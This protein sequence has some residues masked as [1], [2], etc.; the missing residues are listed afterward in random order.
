[1]LFLYLFLFY[2]L[3]LLWLLSL[4]LQI[5][6]GWLFAKVSFW[7][8]TIV[9]FTFTTYLFLLAQRFLKKLFYGDVGWFASWFFSLIGLFYF[10]TYYSLFLCGACEGNPFFNPLILF[11]F[12]PQVLWCIK[13]I[14]FVGGLSC[15]VLSILFFLL[16]SKR[17]C[18]VYLGGS[19]IC[20][21]PLLIG[22]I[23]YQP[24]KIDTG[25]ICFIRPWWHTSKDPMYAGY[26][27][28][29][30]VT[31]CIHHNRDISTIILPESSFG[32]NIYH[33]SEFIPMLSDY[34]PEVKVMFGGQRLVEG[35]L[36]NCYLAVKKGQI[37]FSYDKQ[38][39]V[40][41]MERNSDFLTYIGYGELLCSTSDTFVPGSADQ[42]DTIVING[43]LYQL[44]VCSELLHESKPI[45]G[46]PILF[47][48]NDTWFQFS[49]MRYW[50]ML[51]VR[52]IELRY[53][54]PVLFCTTSGLSNI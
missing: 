7:L 34:S 52:Y 15:I 6:K 39:L 53:D 14:G 43:M 22:F 24:H 2:T 3:Q 40:P 12:V 21:F 18:L 8:L 33:Y 5:G 46:L 44:F 47:A 19:F 23:Y 49:I 51:F 26:R 50:V 13:Y 36:R 9:W 10:L 32:W 1:M 16:Y 37:I 45:K 27:M 30:N 54:V 28:V 11:A 4:L 35:R 31:Q 41:L 29:H 25:G 38:H 17:R 42:D 20:T 48:C